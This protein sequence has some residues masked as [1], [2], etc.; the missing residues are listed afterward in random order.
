M[1]NV[2]MTTG[3]RANLQALQQTN[4]LQEA[5][6]NRLATGKKVNTAL[7]NATSF[8]TALSHKNR[9]NDLLSF[10][11]AIGESIQTIKAADTAIAGITKLIEGAK[12]LAADAKGL[13]GQSTYTQTLTVNTATLGAGVTLEIGG[14][15]FTSLST[16]GTAA[17]GSLDFNSGTTAEMTAMNLA[18][19]INNNVATLVKASVSGATLTITSETGAALDANTLKGVVTGTMDTAGSSTIASSKFIE[20]VLGSGNGSEVAAKVTKYTDFISQI[21]DLKNDA[22]YKGKNLLGGA[23]GGVNDMTVRFG[24][25]HQLS[26]K[27]FDATATAG[28][29]ISATATGSWDSEANIAAD[30]TKMENALTTLR[31]KSSDLSSNLSIISSRNDWISSIAE[32]LSEGADK[33]TLADANEEGANLLMLQ[34]RQSISTSALSMSA[35]AAQSVL[36]LF[37]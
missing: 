3:M 26:V 9:A 11:D 14:Q 22:F 20:S 8:F 4:V 18:A 10:K 25:A 7:D 16:T 17:A 13:V 33:L 6:M 27:S 19:A 31:I 36:R 2:S 5:T 32:T 12:A 24:N 30:I 15:T 29:G 28:L 34:T 37:Q 1:S 23:S 35:Q 21:D